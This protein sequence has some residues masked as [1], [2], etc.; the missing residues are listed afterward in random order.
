MVIEIW[1]DI[2]NYEGL[3]QVSNLGRVKGLK[4]LSWN[5]YSYITKP[6]RILKSSN[7]KG[8]KFVRL[9]KDK[10][11]KNYTIHRLVATAFIE[12]KNNYKEVNHIDGNKLNNNATNLEWCTKSHNIRHAFKMGLNKR[13]KGI[14]NEQA[15]KV[16][17]YD[18]NMKKIKLWGCISD[19]QR[20]LKIDHS[21]IIRCAKHKQNT[22]GGYK[23]EYGL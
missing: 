22:A 9:Y 12:N 6:E 13:R 15:K 3:Y 19:A 20:E 21:A 7:S 17:Q 4:K 2:L 18:K 16:I 14:E 8:Y 5:G 23:W 1:K 10:V 11:A